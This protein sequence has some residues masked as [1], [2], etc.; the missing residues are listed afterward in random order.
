MSEAS[1]TTTATRCGGC[2]AAAKNSVSVSHR[3]D[4]STGK[5]L[6]APV[7]RV[8]RR[9]VVLDEKGLWPAGMQRADKTAAP[10]KKRSTGAA[11]T[12]YEAPK[13]PGVRRCQT[14]S[15]EATTLVYADAT[16]LEKMCR[17]CCAIVGEEEEEEQ[18]RV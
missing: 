14:A 6:W 4:G 3:R 8:G 11:D 18:E 12:L 9:G 7:V 17:R 1:A 10:A 16:K 5:A 13:T 15:I 2:S